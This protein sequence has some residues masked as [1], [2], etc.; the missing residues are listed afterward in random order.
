MAL[1]F[2]ATSHDDRGRYYIDEYGDEVPGQSERDC[3]QQWAFGDDDPTVTEYWRAKMACDTLAMTS[4]P[5][6][7]VREVCSVGAWLLGLCAAL[8]SLCAG[9]ALFGV[10]VVVVAG[11]GTWGHLG[12]P[13]APVVGGMVVVALISFAAL[14]VVGDA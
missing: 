4:A 5:R 6:E 14:W 8:C 13:L 7:E 2:S 10:F 3:P 1:W 11:L 9:A 12:H